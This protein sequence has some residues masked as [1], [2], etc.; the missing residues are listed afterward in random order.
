MTSEATILKELI[1][2]NNPV[3]IMGVMNA[4]CA[5]MAQKAGVKALYLSGAGVANA[6]FGLPDLALTSLKDLVEDVSRI[7]AISNLPLLVDID[8]G[9]G[10][11]LNVKKTALDLYKAGAAGVQIEDQPFAKRCGHLEGKKLVSKNMMV[12]RIEAIRQVCSASEMLIVARTDALGIESLEQTLDRALA[13]QAAGADVLFLEAATQLS[14]YQYFSDK[15]SIPIL[16]NMTEFGKT[17]LF[18]I[19]ELKKAGVGA[20]LYPLSIFRVMN[21][22]AFE[23]YQTILKT[24]TQK[25][26]VSKMQ[27]REQLYQLIDYRQQEQALEDFYKK[28]EQEQQ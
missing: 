2:K 3:Q 7:K 8:T 19:D 4:L 21:H 16:A 10:S 15:L 24:G 22:A 6:S 20:V 26:L 9:F 18:E 27:T 17:P 1:Q 5:L 11:I 14:D 23:G 13:Y 25:S 12:A 28:F